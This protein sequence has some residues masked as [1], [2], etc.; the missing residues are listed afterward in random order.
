M[1][2]NGFITFYQQYFFRFHFITISNIVSVKLNLPFLFFLSTFFLNCTQ[3][4]TELTH[5]NARNLSLTITD[6]IPL[7]RDSLIFEHFDI[8][9]ENSKILLGGKFSGLY[10]LDLSN[11]KLVKIADI[12]RNYG[13]INISL[14]VTKYLPGDKVLVAEIL[15]QGKMYLFDQNRKLVHTK[16]YSD[17]FPPKGDM[18][19]FIC[20]NIDVLEVSKDTIIFGIGIN[21][22]STNVPGWEKE[23]CYGKLSISNN[24][25]SFLSSY[26]TL[27]NNSLIQQSI[28]K[29]IEYSPFIVPRICSNDKHIFLKFIFDNHIYI[30]DK[31]FNNLKQIDFGFYYKQY[32]F[33]LKKVKASSKGD[34]IKQNF[35]NIFI[36]SFN[37]LGNKAYLVYPQPVSIEN[38]P[39]TVE[40]VREQEGLNRHRVLHIIDLEK[41]NE[42]IANLPVILDGHNLV[43]ESEDKIY[44]LGNKHYR[45]DTYIYI[46]KLL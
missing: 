41:K 29:G 15:S 30:L 12:G 33:Y 24:E 18:A 27:N 21:V 26:F 9:F 22:F 36:E 4:K 16:K 28:E 6:S 43:V 8:N 35:C 25:I 44:F 2:W 14:F 37:V 17:L 39:R 45:E 23:D 19:P 32:D 1:G 3:N 34:D 31:Q 10:E 7:F 38:A 20:S 13:Q 46:A 42:F 5:V 11:N 40:E